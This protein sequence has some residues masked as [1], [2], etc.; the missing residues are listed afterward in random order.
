MCSKTIG[1]AEPIKAALASLAE[2]IQLAVVYG[3]T[4]KRTDTASSDVDLLIVSDSMILEQAYIALTSAEQEIAKKDQCN[5][6]Y[7]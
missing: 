7:V 1:L 2:R 6:L 5:A 3:S 4:A